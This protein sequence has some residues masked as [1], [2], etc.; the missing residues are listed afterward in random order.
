M[1]KTDLTKAS[2][3]ATKETKE[4]KAPKTPAGADFS[5]NSYSGVY[6][7]YTMPGLKK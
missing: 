7:G 4:T 5:N 6:G 2:K 3:K 1:K